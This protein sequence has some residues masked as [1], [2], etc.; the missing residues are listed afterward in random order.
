MQAFATVGK[1]QLGPKCAKILGLVELSKTIARKPV[2][3][4]HKAV[5]DAQTD[6]FEG[7]N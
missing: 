3:A 7:L 2:K 1:M 4:R 6:M 5:N